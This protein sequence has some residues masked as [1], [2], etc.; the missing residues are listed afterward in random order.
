MIPVLFAASLRSLPRL[1]RQPPCPAAAKRFFRL[2][3]IKKTGSEQY[4]QENKESKAVRRAGVGCVQ[5][6]P[7]G[8][9]SKGIRSARIENGEVRLFFR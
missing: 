3:L 9:A 5:P 2:G 6:R 1:T 8:V 4:G 7:P